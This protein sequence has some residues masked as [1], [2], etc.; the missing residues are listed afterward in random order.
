[1]N[2]IYYFLGGCYLLSSLFAFGLMCYDK[3]QSKIKGWR[4]PENKLLLAAFFGGALGTLLAVYGWPWHKR[5]KWHFRIL[6]LLFLLL[7][8]GLGFYLVQ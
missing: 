7:H 5:N 1:M 4:I 6:P 3:R 8:L 2:P